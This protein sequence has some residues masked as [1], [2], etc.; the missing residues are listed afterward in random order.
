MHS[1][2]FNVSL[3]VLHVL[4]LREYGRSVRNVNYLR[5]SGRQESLHRRCTREIL[6]MSGMEMWINS[7]AQDCI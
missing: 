5:D 4:L 6:G 2:E 1:T 3:W 7:A